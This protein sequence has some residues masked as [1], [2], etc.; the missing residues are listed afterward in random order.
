MTDACFGL[1]SNKCGEKVFLVLEC[2]PRAFGPRSGD[3]IT[4]PAMVARRLMS[5]PFQAPL[6]VAYLVNHYPKVSHSFIR[7]EILALERQGV[8][9]ERISVR[10]AEDSL[11]DPEDQR[12]QQRTRYVLAR[13]LFYVLLVAIGF[14]LRRPGR[15]LQGLRLALALSR[16]SDRS[17]AH[18]LVY[19]AEACLVA[20]WLADTRVSHLHAHFGTN[21]AE[22]ALLTHALGGPP[23]S[24][25]VHGPEEFDKPEALALR[26]KIRHARFVVAISS[27]GRSQLSRWIEPVDWPKIEIVHCGLEPAFHEVTSGSPAS[28]PR[29]VCVGRLCEQ[30]GQL[31]ALD[32]VAL[33]RQRGVTCELVLAGDGEMRDAVERRSAELGVTDCVRITG[34]LSSGQVRDEILASR[35][36]VMPSFAEGLPVAIMEAMALRRPV[37]STYVAGIPELVR[38][39]REGWLVPASDVAALADAM[40]RCV[41]ASTE[42]L[43]RMSLSARQRVL[44]RHDVDQ[45]AARLR[46]LFS[47]QTPEKRNFSGTLPAQD[48]AFAA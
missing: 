16:R 30:K 47:G 42:T 29:F 2:P 43:E 25:T 34:W 35:A 1:R 36:L 9:V 7:R 22:V 23:Y 3:A 28:A 6:R 32:A 44:E 21:P 18:H 27:Y 20:T 19:L 38:P 11:F 5:D 26:R 31:V 39:E 14:S 15:F 17:L 40:E 45:E 13:G 46:L 48:S 41:V 8:E 33:L 4:D 10:G 37:I 24:F 12:E